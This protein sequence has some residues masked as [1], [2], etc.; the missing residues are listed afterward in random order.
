M[1][2][3][4]PTTF[5]ESAVNPA[6]IIVRQKSVIIDNMAGTARPA[7]GIAGAIEVFR[8]GRVGGGVVDPAEK[9]LN[10]DITDSQVDDNVA[11]RN[12]PSLG[13]VGGRADKDRREVPVELA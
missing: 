13:I 5:T 1:S 3:W 8:E 6:I 4:F 11:N 7:S 2:G 9:L 12:D 10:L